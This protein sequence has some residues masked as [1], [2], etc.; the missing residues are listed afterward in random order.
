[1]T[2]LVSPGVSV[3][4]IDESM[5]PSS[6]GGT[7]P[8]IFFASHEYKT[9]S[10]GTGFASGS[11]PEMANQLMLITS[12]RDLIQTFGTPIFHTDD[13][14]NALHGYELN[15][16]GLLTAYHYLSQANTCYVIRAAIDFSE[17]LP[18]EVPPAG[19]PADGQYWLDLGN[20]IWGVFESNG[21]AVPGLAWNSQDVMNV[22]NDSDIEV[23][24]IGTVGVA[25]PTTVIS[26]NGG[27]LI[28]NTVAIPVAA[29]ATLQD[30]IT[31]IDTALGASGIE[32][33][34]Y[35]MIEQNYL[36]VKNLSTGGQIHIDSLS[37]LSLLND[38]GLVT[39][40]AWPAPK[41]VIGLDGTFSIVL[42]YSDCVIYNKIKP[43]GVFQAT[44]VL[45]SS[46]WFAVGSP[47]WARAQPTRAVGSNTPGSITAQ[48]QFVLSNGTDS[49]TITIAT[50]TIA[51]IV[52]TINS[53]I[54]GLAQSS[55]LKHVVAGNPNTG[56]VI[57]DPSGSDIILTN[58]VGTPLAALGIVTARGHKLTYAPH[59]RVPANS[60]IGDVWIKTTPYNDGASWSLNVFNAD[61]ETWSTTNPPL[62]ANDVEAN[63]LLGA[64][65]TPGSTYVKYNIYGSST[66]PLASHELLEW[67]GVAW[68]NINYVAS[69]SPPVSAPLEGAMW[70]SHEHQGL[71]ADIM[72]SDG[73]QW[74]GYMNYQ[75]N[76]GIDP[77]GILFESAAPKKQSTGSPLV[78]ND[79]WV[80]TSPTGIENFPTMYRYNSVLKSWKRISVTDKT[81]PFGISFYDARWSSNGANDGPRDIISMMTS[82]FVD[83]DAPDPR[84]FPDGYLLWNTRWSSAN[85]KK[86]EPN[87]FKATSGNIIEVNDTAGVDFTETD[88]WVGNFHGTPLQDGG[89][90][91]SQSGSAPDG[92]PYFGRKAQRAMV[93]K[94][95]RAAVNSNLD[96]RSETVFFNLIAC[97]GYP[98]LMTEMITLN[99]D[100]AETAF[101]I[102]DCP[103]RLQ[104]DGTSI[105]K[106][107]NPDLGGNGGTENVLAPS[108]DNP[109][110]GIWYPWGLSSNIDGLEIMI[111]SS[112]IALRIIAHSDQISYPWR[113][114]AGFARGLVTNASTVGYLQLDGT[115]KVALLNNGQRDVLYTNRINPIAY[116]PNRGLVAFGQKTRNAIASDLDRINN[117][118]L[119]NYI[120]YNFNIIAQP[121]LF[122]PNDQQTRD[123]VKS[124]FERFL[125]ELVATRGVYDF[126]VICDDSNNS[127][128]RIDRHELWIDAAIQVVQ[129]VEFI[130]IP[131]RLVPT[132]TDMTSLYRPSSKYN[133]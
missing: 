23:R 28:I 12:P 55:T 53:V 69:L 71:S 20:T 18:R 32:A 104:S 13:Q 110:L 87:H 29:G 98:E 48:N 114:P 123:S 77:I 59:Y 34:A 14:G 2:T 10:G 39:A 33:Y 54:S 52:G 40:Q 21:N 68:I 113:A 9:H 51:G 82:D 42:K 117:A 47:E 30:V 95:L 93:V 6:G 79:L 102:G 46:E 94:A 72:V 70:F 50:A 66:A 24:I 56:L 121:F 127:P 3:S 132:G 86:W 57:S 85:V 109:Y 84:L 126:I 64:N 4:V 44:D 91:V 80:D 63:T 22:I 128:A 16:Y 129:D 36:M 61:A 83:P 60:A 118:R 7:V 125:M 1:M 11:L 26:T 101:I 49:V 81:T 76:I 130:Y 120:R 131:L 73:L 43:Q 88:Y 111:P 133:S 74:R 99:T 122:E 106:W 90:W 62:C 5:Y 112:T 97:P 105:M 75:G 37:T 58:L 89:R 45:S 65:K 67:D 15:E 116:I 108:T 27:N 31:A 92:S 8:M 107:A 38:L 100:R 78:S 41:S 25:T 119:V 17:L 35:R 103:A 96:C 124:V 19:D 115:F